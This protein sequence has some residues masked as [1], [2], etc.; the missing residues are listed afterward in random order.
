MFQFYLETLDIWSNFGSEH[1]NQALSQIT[2]PNRVKLSKI[3]YMG[4][5]ELLGFFQYFSG[6]FMFLVKI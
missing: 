2:I 3:S 1:S 6:I 5:V 4:A